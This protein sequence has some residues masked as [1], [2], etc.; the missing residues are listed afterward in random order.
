L[1]QEGSQIM[2]LAANLRA[3]VERSLNQTLNSRNSELKKDNIPPIFAFDTT[4]KPSQL[5][6]YENHRYIMDWW[7]ADWGDPALDEGHFRHRSIAGLE[8]LGMNVATDGI[9][10]VESGSLLTSNFMEHGTLAG[11]IRQSDYR[12]F[13]LTLYGNLCFAMDSGNRFAPE[14]ALIPGS[15]AGEGAGWTWSPVINSSLQPTLALRWLLCYE[16]GDHDTVHLQKAA[17]K[18]WFAQREK[19]V[20]RNCPTRFGRL[21]WSTESLPG[22]S[23][24]LINVELTQAAKSAFN[25][26]IIVHI[27]H[28]DNRRIKSSSVGRIVDNS[29]VIA[30]GD[31]AGKRKIMIQVE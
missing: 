3:D 7:T 21:T 14:D 8:I 30:P 24:W 9:Y 13:L 4:R 28:T 2:T 6:S 31:F 25:T 27:H 18:S 20:V 26:E 29:V 23:G 1:A 15:H 12:P 22:Q 10:G 17:P 16:E 5:S 19:I 11:R